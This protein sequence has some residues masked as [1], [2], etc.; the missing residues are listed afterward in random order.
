MYGPNVDVFIDG[1]NWHTEA[2]NMMKI[3]ALKL[4][5]G[6][7]NYAGSPVP[8]APLDT[9][10]AASRGPMTTPR[11]VRDTTG[12]TLDCASPEQLL[13]QSQMALV[14]ERMLG[15]ALQEEDLNE[16]VSGL[17]QPAAAA[18]CSLQKRLREMNAPQVR[19]KFLVYC[20]DCT[21]VLLQPCSSIMKY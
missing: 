3:A 2:R 20:C 12:S 21:H 10:P 11:T 16:A 17:A 19:E 15:G 9:S 13:G 18:I 4:Q 6:S 5:Q 8:A 7:Q 1:K 14:V